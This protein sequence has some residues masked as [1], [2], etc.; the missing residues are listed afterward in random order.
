MGRV[1]VGAQKGAGGGHSFLDEA[2]GT[3]LEA[4]LAGGPGGGR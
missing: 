2:G 1:W 4:T 3:A